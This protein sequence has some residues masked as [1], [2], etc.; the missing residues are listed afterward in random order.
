MLSN[1]SGIRDS[2]SIKMAREDIAS[3]EHM[4]SVQVR[5]RIYTV[6]AF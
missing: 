1:E 5:M 6:I 2:L 3:I 4:L